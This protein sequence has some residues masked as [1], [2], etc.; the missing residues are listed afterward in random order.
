MCHTLE[1]HQ[2]QHI[3]QESERVATHD[4]PYVVGPQRDL[5][6]PQDFGGF[7]HPPTELL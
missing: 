7:L 2:A 6:L 4:L 1:Q 5:Q 3:A